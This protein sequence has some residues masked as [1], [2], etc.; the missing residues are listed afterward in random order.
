MEEET[1]E[2]GNT[3]NIFGNF[4]KREGDDV[5]DN[6]VVKGGRKYDLSITY[7]FYH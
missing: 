3:D 7:D 1:K 2:G 5:V 6:N 4:I